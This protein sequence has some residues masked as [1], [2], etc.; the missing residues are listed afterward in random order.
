MK[1]ILRALSFF[2]ARS[3]P[4]TVFSSNRTA[5]PDADPRS[6]AGLTALNSER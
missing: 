3:F 2:F 6:L 1:V 4:R 5:G